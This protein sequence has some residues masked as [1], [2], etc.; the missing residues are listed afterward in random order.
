MTDIAPAAA[1]APEIVT[2]GTGWDEQV[3]DRAEL[4]VTFSA[5][6]RDRASAVRDLGKRVAAAEPALS[7]PG[8]TVR[9]RRLW[10]HT[11]WRGNRPSGCRASEDLALLVTDVAVLE[12]L[13][14]ALVSAEPAALNGPRWTL[15]DPSAAL[16]SAQ[17]RA[18][19][20]A[21]ERA[22]GYAAALG[23]RLGPLRRLSEAAEH[24]AP[25]AYRMAARAEDAVDVHDL[26]LE[27]EPVRVTARC[28]TAWTLLP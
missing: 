22:E 24:G 1:E 8:L 3:A 18:V 9:S 21:R 15:A 19:S 6:G 2:E 10:V 14:N 25:I 11:E 23:G 16:R 26:G 17:R 7:T 13:L 12:E 27:P 28:S 4:D 5:T 20:D